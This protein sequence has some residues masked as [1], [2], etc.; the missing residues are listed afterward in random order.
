VSPLFWLGVPAAFASQVLD[1]FSPPLV[2]SISSRPHGDI[3]FSGVLA[4]AFLDIGS[5]LV[6][7]SG[8]S[9]T[10]CVRKTE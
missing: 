5:V 3:F 1:A 7:S 4:F 6:A 10:S 2:P 8:N 9:S